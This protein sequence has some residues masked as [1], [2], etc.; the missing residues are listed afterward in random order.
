MLGLA[1]LSQEPVSSLSIILAIEILILKDHPIDIAP[2]YMV[3][4]KILSWIVDGQNTLL[5]DLSQ[6]ETNWTFN[7]EEE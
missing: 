3:E 4:P 6:I 5:W 2:Y 1:A 7:P